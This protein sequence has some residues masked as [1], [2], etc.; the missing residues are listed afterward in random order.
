MY[1]AKLLTIPLLTLLSSFALAQTWEPVTG[2]DN[3]SA[4][5]SDTVM[6]G[7]LK[8]SVTATATYNSDGT[9]ELKAWGDTFPR[10]WQVKS[11]DQACIDIEDRTRC[12]NVEKDTSVANQYRARDV[13]NGETVIFSVDQRQITVTAGSERDTGGAAQPSAEEIAAKLANPNTPMAS[14]TFRLQ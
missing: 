10:S 13:D 9:G 8:D 6:T 14:L 7:T 1:Y 3:L 5:F 2:V 4:L 11:E 12:Y